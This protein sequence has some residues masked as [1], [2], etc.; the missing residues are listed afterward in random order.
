MSVEPA[1]SVRAFCL[2]LL[3]SGDLATK[4]APPVAR[5]GAALPDGAPGPAVRV[6]RPVRGRGLEMAG[7]ADPLPKPRE[8]WDPARRARCLARFAHHELMAAELF[9]WALLRWPGLPPALRRGLVGALADEQRHCRM[10]LDRLEDHGGR[11]ADHQRSDYFW[12]QAP[13]IAAAPH[14]PRAFLCAMGLTLE[15]A[16]LD[17]PLLY[18]DAFRSVG[19]EASAR[20]CQRVHDDEL[21]HVRLAHHWLRRL[22][23]GAPSDLAAYS[24]AVPF[25]LSL[26]RAKGRRFDA[27]ARRRAGL[28]EEFIEGVRRA[29]S[30]QNRPLRPS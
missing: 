30:S 25:P 21:A 2:R 3:F 9:A 8:L 7:G 24:E 13:A 16:N 26:A 4:L 29:R 14:G 11:L 23:G 28:S 18:R 17:F 10:Y 20:V 19:D 27:E 5:D 1:A 22:A 6:E 15:Q 12:R